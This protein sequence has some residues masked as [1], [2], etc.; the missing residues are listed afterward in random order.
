MQICPDS[1]IAPVTMGATTVS[2]SASSR[3]T[4][5]DLPP[6]SRVTLAIRSAAMA[7]TP[8]P[9]AVEPVK[10]TLSTPGCATSCSPAFLPAGTMLSRP[11]GR[12]VAV[13]PWNAPLLVAIAKIAPAIVAGCAVVLKPAPE[14]PL[15]SPARPPPGHGAPPPRPRGVGPP[16]RRMP[17]R[18]ERP[19]DPGDGRRRPGD[20]LRAQQCRGAEHG[21]RCPVPPQ[22]H[23]DV[24][25]L[26]MIRSLVRTP[27]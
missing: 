7:I 14:P 15:S 1:I 4:A 11:C 13:T 16:G 27:G 8:R 19:G 21:A 26:L 25:L 6:S 17:T 20:H 24:L 9:A 3:M 10:L 12:V 18:T 22:A 23:R 2:T 5:A